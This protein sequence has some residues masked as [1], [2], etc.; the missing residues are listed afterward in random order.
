MAFQTGYL[1][2]PVKVGSGER[3]GSVNIILSATTFEDSLK[4]G[5]FAKLDTGSIDNMDASATPVIAG[6][7][8]RNVASPV[9]DGGVIDSGLFGQV[10]YMRQGLVTVDVVTGDT[11]AQFGTVYANNTTDAD[12]GKATT[13]ATDGSDPAVDNIDT[14]A[15]FIQEVQA[16]VWL[17][18]LK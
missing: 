18:R 14:G 15:E 6:V 2:D 5:R 4:V 8:L 16:G 11:P 3:F 13:D 17:V 10:E 9:E 7:V 12:Y 1:A